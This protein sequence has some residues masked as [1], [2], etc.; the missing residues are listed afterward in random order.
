MGAS[1]LTEVARLAGV[2]PATAS[3]AVPASP[4]TI[5]LPAGWF[6]TGRMIE[7]KDGTQK[8]AKL[9]NLLDRGSDFDRGTFVYA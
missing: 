3:I 9:L 4:A 6:Q 2:S 8:T 1:T 7:F 5:V